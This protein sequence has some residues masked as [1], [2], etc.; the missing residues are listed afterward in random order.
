MDILD[1]RGMTK[2][3]VGLLTKPLR[4]SFL[5]ARR[6]VAGT[7]Y[8]YLPECPCGGFRHSPS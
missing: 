3:Y 8:A 7:A 5:G 6:D 4:V 2:G 1:P